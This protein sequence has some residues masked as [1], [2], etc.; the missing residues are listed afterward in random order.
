MSAARIHLLPMTA[1]FTVSCLIIFFEGINFRFSFLQPIM[2]AAMTET[3]ATSE[4]LDLIIN[5]GNK[6]VQTSKPYCILALGFI[7]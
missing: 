6:A 4:L 3:T 1:R 7:A 5:G 2:P